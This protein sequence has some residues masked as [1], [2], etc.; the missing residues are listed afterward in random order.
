MI[1]QGSI[2]VKAALQYQKREI[3]TIYVDNTKKDRDIDYL[4]HIAAKRRLSVAFVDRDFLDC[5]AGSS[6]HGGIIAEVGARQN[7]NWESLLQEEVIFALNGIEDPYNMGYCLR[8]LCAF[9]FTAVLSDNRQFGDSEA[10]VLR[11]GAGAFDQI[12][13]YGSKDMEKQLYLLKQQGYTLTALQ[14]SSHSCDLYDSTFLGKQV[15]VLGGEQRGIRKSSLALCERKIFIPYGSTFRNA[16]NATSALAVVAG[17]IFRSR[18][19]HDYIQ[20]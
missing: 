18:R 5:K 20:R 2:A 10:I 4:L 8:T 14:R 11:S 6:K 16:L 13:Y 9:G 7:D 15:V 1:I 17:E 19:Q 12:K 3:Y